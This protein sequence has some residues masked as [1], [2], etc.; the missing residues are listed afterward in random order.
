MNKN[1]MAIF[2]TEFR[3]NDIVENIVTKKKASYFTSQVLGWHKQALV[4]VTKDVSLWEVLE[5]LNEIN[6]KKSELD[7]WHY[8]TFLLEDSLG[9]EARKFEKKGSK[10]TKNITI[11]WQLSDKSGEVPLHRQSKETQDQIW[12]VLK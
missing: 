7:K 6:S 3:Q 8:Y 10:C 11:Y 12:E 5:K 4:H 9:I 1:L 2:H